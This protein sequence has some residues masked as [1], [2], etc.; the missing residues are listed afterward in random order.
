M[1]GI[2]LSGSDAIFGLP[3]LCA[4]VAVDRRHA[5][6]DA[7]AIVMTICAV[8]GAFAD[9]FYQSD[10]TATFRPDRIAFASASLR[11]HFRAG[12]SIR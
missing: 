12:I 8:T 1:T 7:S 11:P 2:F 3:K 4:V 10:A 9:Y 6:V 5:L